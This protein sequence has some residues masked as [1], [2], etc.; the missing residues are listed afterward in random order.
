MPKAS[1]SKI[2]HDIKLKQLL[3]LENFVVFWKKTLILVIS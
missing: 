1:I 3:N 2:Y